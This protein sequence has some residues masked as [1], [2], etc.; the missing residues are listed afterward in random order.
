MKLWTRRR[1]AWRRL[2]YSESE[3]LVA[4]FAYGH[5]TSSRQRRL[6]TGHN[7]NFA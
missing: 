7:A 6:T 2:V 3:H 1:R 5:A 4:V